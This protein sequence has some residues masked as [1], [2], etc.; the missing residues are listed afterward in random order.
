MGEDF[1]LEKKRRGGKGVRVGNEGGEEEAWTDVGREMNVNKTTMGN[2]IKDI[3]ITIITIII[4]AIVAL[5]H[6]H[7]PDHDRGEGREEEK[8]METLDEG[9]EGRGAIHQQQHINNQTSIEDVHR[10][11][12]GI[13][14]K[15]PILR[16]DEQHSR[17]TDLPLDHTGEKERI[18]LCC[19]MRI[20]TLDTSGEREVI[21]R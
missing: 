15:E 10:F 9:E 7:D 6:A 4:A 20:R 1:K 18:P 5:R 12:L 17:T 14:A 19:Q 8:M 21:L 2:L 16:N 3:I 11:L 13:K